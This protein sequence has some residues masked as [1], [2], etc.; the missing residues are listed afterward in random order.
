M[1]SVK[2]NLKKCV[3]LFYITIFKKQKYT[4]KR[5][6]LVPWSI[7]PIKVTSLILKILQ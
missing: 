6:L 2:I 7:A 3:I 5:L 1:H 4:K